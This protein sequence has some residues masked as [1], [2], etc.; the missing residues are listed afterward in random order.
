MRHLSSQDVDVVGTISAGLMALLPNGLLEEDMTVTLNATIISVSI[1]TRDSELGTAIVAVITDDFVQ[2]LSALTE[3]TLVL[4]EE[5]RVVSTRTVEYP[6]PPP[7]APLPMD[8]TALH[9]ERSKPQS[10]AL[11]IALIAVVAILLSTLFCV[12]RRL[13]RV[14]Q[15][16]HQTATQQQIGMHRT[17]RNVLAIKRQMVFSR[18]PIQPISIGQTAARSPRGIVSSEAA[19]LQR[20]ETSV[21]RAE[22]MDEATAVPNTLT[23]EAME[24]EIQ[25]TSTTT[26]QACHEPIAYR[27]GTRGASWS[28]GASSAS[29]LRYDDGPP[30]DVT[31]I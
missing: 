18:A 4:Q 15:T 6:Y 31:H 14:E 17:M 12:V 19:W 8:A 26:H 7:T 24:I 5:A 21:L 10:H 2:D 22:H 25:D 3:I 13:R 30:R 23:M 28:P 27:S 16:A 9:N 1:V 29:G 20:N 11:L